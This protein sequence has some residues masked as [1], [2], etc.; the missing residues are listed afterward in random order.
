MDQGAAWR[1]RRSLVAAYLIFSSNSRFYISRVS[2]HK[3]ATR[4]ASNVST[5]DNDFDLNCKTSYSS[6]IQLTIQSLIL[7]KF[8]S[9]NEDWLTVS[10]SAHKP[11]Y[12][13]FTIPWQ[14][15]RRRGR[16]G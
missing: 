5:I 7:K 10:H 8:S 12:K 16:E 4:L 15:A 14:S 9:T 1:I 11:R 13:M 2:E 3:L 6:H